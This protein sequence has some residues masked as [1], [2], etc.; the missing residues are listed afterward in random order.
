MLWPYHFRNDYAG[1]EWWNRSPDPEG[2][3]VCL[4]SKTRELEDFMAIRDRKLR[5]QGFLEA[6]RWAGREGARP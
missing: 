2:S 5:D 1:V 3:T 6:S 4:L